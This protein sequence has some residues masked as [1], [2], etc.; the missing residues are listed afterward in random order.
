MRA[1]AFSGGKDSLAAY[2]LTRATL[3]CAIF[4]DTGFSYP[5]TQALV[6]WLGTQLP[7]HVV[8]SDRAGQNAA[9]GIPADVVP[10]EWTVL[11]QACTHPKPMTIQ[12]SFLCCYDN[13][14]QPLFAKAR[15][16]GVTHLVD[17]QRHK[18]SHRGSVVPNAVMQGIVREHPLADWTREQV[19]DYLLQFR[20]LPEQ[21][22]LQHSSLDC[23]DCPAYARETQDRVAWTR[24]HYPD[25]H[26]AYASRRQAVEDALTA[27]LS[28]IMTGGR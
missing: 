5:D 17:G 11:G 6:Q 26:R 21:F 2:Y 1:L 27:A 10:V 16:L 9:H 20:D 22:D 12:P 28:P 23:Y 3:D 19:L 24:Q 7:V 14:S 15:E 25:F 4:V 8:R 18:E 13:I